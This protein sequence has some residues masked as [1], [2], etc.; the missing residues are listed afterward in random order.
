MKKK[1]I[2]NIVLLLLPLLTVGLAAMP[3]SVTVLRELQIEYCSF[4]GTLSDG[5]R[6]MG[7]AF[8]G[9]MTFVLFGLLVVYV[10]IK[11]KFLLNIA[12]WLSLGAATLSVLP[13]LIRSEPMVIP[14]VG[15]ALLLCVEALLAFIYYKK[16]EKLA[17]NPGIRLK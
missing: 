5:S 12:C 17:V 14:N 3:D 10:V 7:L 2:W 8:C 11:K 9:L 6:P 13:L 1:L 15:V 4:F 16:D